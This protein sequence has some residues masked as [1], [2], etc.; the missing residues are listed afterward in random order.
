MERVIEMLVEYDQR[1]RQM[2]RDAQETRRETLGKMG[3]DKR[4]MAQQYQSR[5]DHRIA[6]YREQAE[7]EKAEQLAA[8]RAEAETARTRLRERFAENR[9][10]WLD[11][12]TARCIG[13]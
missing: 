8:L 3:D 2:V 13:G 7:A 12:L 4:E 11:E 6:Y 5:S 1:G 9:E 10:A